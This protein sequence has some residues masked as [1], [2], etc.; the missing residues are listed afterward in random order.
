MMANATPKS[1]RWVFLGRLV[2]GLA[3]GVLLYAVG[4][5]KAGQPALGIA[6]EDDWRRFIVMSRTFAFFAPLPLLF[7]FGNLPLRRLALWSFAAAAMIALFGWLAPAPVWSGAPPVVTVWLFSLIVIYILH[8][9]IQAAHDDARPIASYATYFDRAWRHGFQAVLA[10]IFVGAFWVVVSI[11][12]NL[13]RLIGVEAVFDAVFSDEFGWIASAT[14]FALG[15]HWTDADAGLTRGARQIGLA[16]LA[17]L[18]ILMTL[19]LTAF[20]AALPVTG[21]DALWDTKRAT[22]LLLNAAATMIFLINAAFQAGEAPKSTLIRHAVRF[23]VAPLMATAVLA[24]LGLYLRVDQ[25]GLTPARVVATAELLIVGFYAL[26]YL[27]AA[28]SPGAWLHAVKPVNIAGAL[29]VVLILIALMTPISDPARISVADQVARLDRGEVEPDNFDF[30]F[31]A[32]PRSGRWG[33][34]A[35]EKL[36]ARSGDARDERIAFLAKHP[37]EPNGWRAADQ[38]FGDRRRALVLVGAGDIPDAALLPRAAP[39]PVADC[40][41]SMKATEERRRLEAEQ[42]RIEQKIGKRLASAGDD[43]D[44]REN[45]A[46]K[47]GGRC[48]ARLL[49]LDF[50]GDDDLLILN[51]DAYYAGSYASLVGITRRD[52]QWVYAGRASWF[53]K[54]LCIGERCDAP[55]DVARRAQAFEVLRTESR[56]FNDI[57]I[58]GRR[59]QLVETPIRSARDIRE[60]IDVRDGREPPSQVFDAASADDF[61]RQCWPLADGESICLSRFLDIDGDGREEFALIAIDGGGDV[62]AHVWR[63]TETGWR[64][65]AQSLKAV[66]VASFDESP[67]TP[68]DRQAERRHAVDT[69]TVVKPL[70]ADLDAGG[71]RL[72]LEYGDN[73]D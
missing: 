40:V 9:F 12:A 16:M 58:A 25:Y 22:V 57:A 21:L 3:A 49:D 30:G 70:L 28:I 36:A 55:E 51:D 63:Q 35:L 34:S 65:A 11:G 48:L 61:A 5:M 18:S 54:P 43:D 31:L 69:A 45:A 15:V 27:A 10:L 20:L 59:L 4:L 44:L 50:D 68:A 62:S 6:S 52:D 53:V 19:I 13:F 29:F 23:S 14:A 73:G 64:S 38:T 26:G 32:D 67:G 66:K 71:E 72:V 1:G 47:N 7:G 33:K 46:Q 24:A 39:D 42:R 17:W 60:T 37:V 56:Q 8:E 41:V 2:L